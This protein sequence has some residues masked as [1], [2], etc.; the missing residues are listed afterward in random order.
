MMRRLRNQKVVAGDLHDRLVPPAQFDQALVE[1]GLTDW[2]VEFVETLEAA[3]PYRL[4][5]CGLVIALRT[6]DSSTRRS[7]TYALIPIRTDIAPS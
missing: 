2:E 7:L 6:A 1:E 5:D 4:A 3:A